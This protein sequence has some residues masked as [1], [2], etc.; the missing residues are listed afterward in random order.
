M[1]ESGDFIMNIF[2]K[3]CFLVGFSLCTLYCDTEES[4][5][6]N[7]V[8]IDAL[9]KQLDAMQSK[10]EKEET[11][12]ALQAHIDEVIEKQNKLLEEKAT[13]KPAQ[14]QTLSQNDSDLD[15]R[16]RRIVQEELQKTEKADNGTD[17][18]HEANSQTAE[19]IEAT[20]NAEKNAPSLPEEQ[21]EGMAQYELALNL[22][23]KGSYKEAAGAFGRI[24]KT[25]PNDP[26]SA[27]ALVHLA[28][29]L[30]KQGELE[31][32]SIVCEAALNK[33]LDALHQVDCQLI[34]L[35]FA[36]SKGNDT[37]VAKIMN[38][39]KT[40]PLNAEQQESLDKIAGKTVK[41]AAKAKTPETPKE[42]TKPKATTTT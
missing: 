12:K 5:R 42:P 26:I 11:L 20:K 9:Q 31:S 8:I 16:I 24:V 41:Q 27:K 2:K 30:E 29:C 21:S 23:N 39:L 37:D 38:Q 6:K 7:E 19:K 35:R 22:Y 33:K 3:S 4:I 1:H 14:N 15:S 13:G 40:L 25:Y 32:A 17:P 36:K 10:G 34:C 28:Y 18:Y